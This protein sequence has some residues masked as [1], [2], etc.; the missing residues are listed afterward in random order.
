LE[1]TAVIGLMKGLPT[2][3][4]LV[5]DA[6]NAQINIAALPN[7]VQPGQTFTIKV[8]MT[9]AQPFTVGVYTMSGVQVKSYNGRGGTVFNFSCALPVSGEYIITLFTKDYK[10]SRRVIVN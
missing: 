5:A 9:V 4:G 6:R 1:S 3:T 2:A 7:I 8:S 10:T